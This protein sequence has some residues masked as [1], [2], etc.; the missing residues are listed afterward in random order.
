MQTVDIDALLDRRS[1]RPRGGAG[2]RRSDDRG[3][4]VTVLWDDAALESVV[5]SDGFLER[6]GPGGVH[7]SMS[8]V[9][10]R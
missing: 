5:T 1:G 4:L 8:T 6:L 2:G 7:V 10:L 9:S 3:S